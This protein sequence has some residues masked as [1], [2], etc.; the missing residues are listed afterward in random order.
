MKYYGYAGKIL[1]I[2]LTNGEI[3]KEALDF[4]L[5]KKFIGSCGLHYQLAY[6]L[7]HPGSDPLSSDSPILIGSGPLIGTLAPSSGKIQATVKFPLFASQDGKHYIASSSSGSNRFGVMMKNAGYD[8]I[9]ITGRANRPVYLKILDDNVEICDARQLWGRRDIYQTTEDLLAEY[10]GCGV[11]AIG[12]AG[13]NLVRFAEALVDKHSTLGKGGLGAVMGSKNLKA[14]IVKG[15]KGIELAEPR[16]SMKISREIQQEFLNNPRLKPWQE[17]GF[18]SEWLEFMPL[19][20]PGRWT[21]ERWD[22]LYGREKLNGA[23]SRIGSC[24]ACMTGCK[25][26]LKIQNGEFPGICSWTGDGLHVAGIGGS[27]G[28]SDWSIAL[29]IMDIL[30]RAGMDSLS[31]LA[32]AYYIISSFKRGNITEKETEGLVLS[33]DYTSWIDLA[34]AAVHRTGLGD[35]MAEGWF[36]VSRKIGVDLIS[37]LG[38]IKGTF[39]YYDARSCKLD[40]RS[41]GMVVNPRGSHHPQGHW[42]TSLH[43]PVKIVKSTAPSLGM[44][45]EDIERIFTDNKSIN[46]ARLTKHVLDSGMAM[47][48]LGTCVIPRMSGFPLDIAM[49]AELYSAQTGIEV[50][51]SELKQKGERAYNMLKLLNVREGFNREDDRFP[52]VW[53]KPRKT[54]DG[55]ESMTDFYGTKKAVTKE[56]AEMM[57]DEYYDERGWD[58]KT[59]IPT[60]KKLA[61]LNLAQ[62]FKTLRN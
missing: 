57:L 49:L 37:K 27:M 15:T 41:F 53:F 58:T 2:N 17:Q 14:I 52:E 6:D 33:E 44:T 32:M 18:H 36:A 4:E 1:R 47:D 56:D 10:K 23:L 46:T 28:V 50:T 45:H 35:A 30:N 16:K 25:T 62:Y 12:A 20:N 59:G 39:C 60:M 61:E 9:I 21:M 11:M 5:V 7:I 34:E 51:P 48:C 24:T 26:E 22:E 55:M 54:P 8:S 42:I 13:E 19:I 43:A 40:P 38:I 3:E 29:K 31:F